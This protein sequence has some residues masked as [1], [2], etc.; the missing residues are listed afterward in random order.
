MR[1]RLIALG[2]AA[3]ALLIFY[4]LLFPKPGGAA[5]EL[6]VSTDTGP[7]GLAAA[8]SWMHAAKIPVFAL[9]QRY[10]GRDGLSGGTGNLLITTLPQHLPMSAAEQSL[11]DRWIAR[12]N[13]VLILA[14]LDDTPRWSVTGDEGLRGVLSGLA[15]FRFSVHTDPS[16]A[17]L[18]ALVGS[19]TTLEPVGRHALL[20][21]VHRLRDESALPASHWIGQPDADS[22]ALAIAQRQ[23]PGP[24][25]R[26]AVLWVEPH[27]AGQV[28]LSAFAAPF[29]NAQIDQ[30]DNAQLLANIIAW[31]RAPS[32]RVI[33]DDAHQGV[34][35]SYDP[36]AFY[37]DP[38]LH[39][40]VEW[41][42]LL[43]LVWVLGSQPLRSRQIA[44]TPV[45][46]IALVEA[47]GRFFSG[48]V[49][50]REAAH[51]LLQNFFSEI[52]RRLRQPADGTPP[53]EWLAAQP[54]VPPDRYAALR[55]HAA[56]VQGHARVSLRRLQNLLSQLRRS[57][58]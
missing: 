42:L 29:S 3:A 23:A 58:G 14:A 7:D 47:A 21:D 4:A 34:V 22:G 30:A 1:S 20:T 12:G 33:F 6:P 5:A 57:I 43:W 40:S 17:A 25:E 44:W 45:D 48:R 50:P 11:L 55:D 49:P 10:D 54:G 35:D 18:P 37:A 9:R 53:W 15:G 26:D 52:H 32:G 46:E 16:H 56:R 27:G 13:T 28:I 8:W 31:S 19:T 39:H 2:L 51:R 38:R 36:H 41:L 24:D